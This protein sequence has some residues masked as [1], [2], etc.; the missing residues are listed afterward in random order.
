MKQLFK[1]FFKNLKEYVSY[2]MKVN[3]K[4]LFVNTIILVCIL[5]LS[6]FAYVPVGL[7]DDLIFNFIKIFV[8]MPVLVTQIYHWIFNLLGFALALCAF[9]YMFNLRFKDVKEKGLDNKVEITKKGESK[10]TLDLPKQKD[11]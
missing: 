3:F 1:D 6:T 8:T 2:L 5:V 9:A 10:V 7:L 4:E 11:K